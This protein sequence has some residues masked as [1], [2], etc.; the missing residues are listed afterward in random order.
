MHLERKML[1]VRSCFVQPVESCLPW[2]RFLFFDLLYILRT[3]KDVWRMWGG[4]WGIGW[5]IEVQSSRVP[6]RFEFETHSTRLE[7]RP[8]WTTIDSSRVGCT[9]YVVSKLQ[10]QTGNVSLSGQR[11]TK[12]YWLAKIHEELE[13]RY[14]YSQTIASSTQMRSRSNDQ[15]D[16]CW[17]QIDTLKKCLCNWV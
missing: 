12:P 16:S 6:P 5:Y 8:T 15:H 2:Q 13:P 9:R 1:I 14:V 4:D 10:T 11:S 7:K 17:A 3:L